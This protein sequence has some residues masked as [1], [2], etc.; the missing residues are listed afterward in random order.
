MSDAVRLCRWQK[1]K[2]VLAIDDCQDLVDSRDQLDLERLAHIDTHA[3]SR[4]TVIRVYRE[5]DSVSFPRPGESAIRLCPLTRSESESY[6][7]TK[8]AAAGRGEPTFTPRAV[9]RLLAVSEGIPLCSID[10]P[11]SR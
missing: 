10:L 2:V 7:T 11:R 9:Q 6:I 4:L 5:D 8:L 1:F 3:E